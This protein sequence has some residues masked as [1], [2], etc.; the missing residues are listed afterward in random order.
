M[1]KADL[2]T[3]AVA[4]FVDLLLVIGLARLPDVLGFLS[5]CGYILVRDGLFDRRSVGKKLIGLYVASS[6]EA[7][8]AMTYRESI[9]RNVPFA[10]VYILFLVP[11]AGWALGPLALGVESLVAIG[12]ERGMR[13]GDMLARTI[14]VQNGA[15]T[16]GNKPEERSSAGQPGVTVPQDEQH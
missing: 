12:D 13:I 1:Q 2:T 15:A 6:E 14:V 9:I 8:P 3:R 10:V 16:A 11:Y 7:G 5:A 4:G